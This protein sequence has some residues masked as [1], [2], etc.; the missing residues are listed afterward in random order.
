MTAGMVHLPVRESRSRAALRGSRTGPETATGGR[1]KWEVGLRKHT[2]WKHSEVCPTSLPF[3]NHTPE[4]MITTQC[5]LVAEERCR[6][7]RTKV[8]TY[9]HVCVHI[10]TNLRKHLSH[11][12]SEVTVLG[13]DLSEL[14]SYC[15]VQATQLTKGNILLHA[16]RKKRGTERTCDSH[17]M[18]V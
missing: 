13:C 3:A 8:C 15:K 17:T 12:V 5:L 16:C 7:I 11:C 9:V 18:Q 14:L 4:A 10:R 6:Y 1:G 2:K